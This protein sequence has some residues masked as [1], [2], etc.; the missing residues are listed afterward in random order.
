[1]TKQELI[2][3]IQ[4]TMQK[5]EV[6]LALR[7]ERLIELPPEIGQLNQLKLLDL[8]SNQLTQL[9][10]EIA[11]LTQLQWLNLNSNQLTQLPPKR[12]VTH[13]NDLK[14]KGG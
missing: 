2:E 3:E 14:C 8:G 10:P 4:S 12:S 1:M 7:G 9:P 13:Q 11:Q 5:R 6:I